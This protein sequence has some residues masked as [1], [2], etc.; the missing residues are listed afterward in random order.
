[1]I[2]NQKN[3]RS[4]EISCKGEIPASDKCLR[5]V[6]EKLKDEGCEDLLS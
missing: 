6:V 1:M 2:R 4:G 5:H 3:G